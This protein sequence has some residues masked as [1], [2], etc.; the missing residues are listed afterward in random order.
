MI[1]PGSVQ[2]HLSQTGFTANLVE[3]NNIQNQSIT[4]DATPYCF[5]LP[6]DA[7]PESDEDKT[8]PTFIERKQNYQSI[9]GLIGWLAQSTRPDLA[10]SHLFLSAYCNKPSQ[11]HINAALCVLHYI[12]STIDYGFTFISTKTNPLHTFLSFP[13]TSDTE[14]YTDGMPLKNNQNHCLTTYSNA[15]WGS[16]MG[17]AIRAEIQLPLFRFWSMS[18]T[19]IFRSGGRITWKSDRQEQTTLSSCEAEI[20]ATSMGSRLFVN[21]CNMISHLSSLGHPISD[22]TPPTPLFK[23]DNACVQWC[24]NMTTKGICHIKNQEAQFAS[25]L[26]MGLLLRHTLVAISTLQIFLLQKCETGPTSAAFAIPSCAKALILLNTISTPLIHQKNHLTSPPL[27]TS[28]LHRQQTTSHPG[29]QD[30]LMSSYL[31][32]SFG[33]FPQSHAYQVLDIAYYLVSH[34]LCAGHYEGSYWECTVGYIYHL[35]CLL[36]LSYIK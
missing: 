1:T 5:G 16:Q 20:C 25:G 33:F 27:T 23:D 6:I 21:V 15:C 17:N 14:A 18:G 36:I 34:L 30:I 32:H 31:N 24:H 35:P 10:P 2:V 19:I 8:C 26:K 28:T 7:I 22:A 11:S 9:V 3:E 4:H 13:H 29:H 12:H